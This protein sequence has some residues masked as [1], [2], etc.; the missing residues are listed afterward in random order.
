MAST[1]AMFTA[2]SGLNA[3]SRSLDTVG[4]NIANVNTTAYKSSRLN[5][6]ENFSTTLRG[7]A[8]PTDTSGGTNPIQIGLGVTIAGATRNFTQGSTTPT[9]NPTD[10]A[11]EGDGF[12]VANRASENLFTRA[13]SFRLDENGTLVTPEG[14]P[15]R[16]YTADEDFVI[17]S[18]GALSDIRIQLGSRTIAEATTNVNFSG[19]LDTRGTVATRGTRISL[20]GTTTAGLALVTT[21]APSPAPGA[22][23]VLTTGNLL[24]DIED[25]SL[26]GSS[27]PLFTAGQSI[28]I[29][30]A[31]RGTATLPTATFPITATTTVGDLLTFLNGTLGIQTTGGANPDGFTPGVTLD[32]TTG[33]ITV[34]GNTGEVNDL[35][36][37]ASAIRL[38]NSGGGT[39]RLPLASTEVATADGES[40]RTSFIAYDS[41]G[42]PSTV[43]MTISLESTSNAGTTWRY[44][45]DS[46]DDTDP[47]TPIGSGTI[48]FD[49]QGRLSTTTP[50]SVTVDRAGTGAV[51]PLTFT[52]TFGDGTNGVTA[53]ALDSQVVATSS[54]G[55]PAGTL[56]SFAVDRSGIVFGTFSNS[57][58]RPLAQL[59]LANFRNPPGLTDLG[60]NLF[61]VSSN[62]GLAQIGPPGQF[63]TGSVVGG[64]L[65]LSN[66]DISQ[67]FINL[68]LAS[69]GFSAAS[70]VITTTDQLVQQLLV[71]GR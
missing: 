32:P 29:N 17:N 10:L 40:V 3:S 33:R 55:A 69:T 45:L 44:S 30:G 22:G 19:N 12:F 63:A 58:V 48:S 65:E 34:V 11:I 2:L 60:N 57:L 54:D 24:V 47:S 61:Q 68:I 6:S 5:L 28:Q 7:A 25:P 66:V 36:L 41:L 26:P 59:A 43:N 14:F 35:D 8:A 46:A 51:T 31:K 64:A 53:V 52:L 50:A 15:V 20:G 71:L 67:E 38:L 4:N 70:R 21:P 62:S 42:N 1:I 27:T 49:T 16:G 39:V 9:G 37:P 56:Q 13:G 18:S 23:E